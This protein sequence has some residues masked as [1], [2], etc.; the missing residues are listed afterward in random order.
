MSSPRLGVLRRAFQLIVL[1]WDGTAVENRRADAGAVRDRFE[2]LL[3]LGM[4][5]AVTTGTNFDNVDRQ[6]SAHIE[7]PHKGRLFV[8]T[9]R[10]SE[11]YGFGENSVPVVLQRRV[12]TAKEDSLLT[13]IVDAA[14]DTLS[15][16]TGLRFDVVYDRL[17]RR[18]L[19][20]L[21]LPEWADPP[22]SALGAVQAAADERLRRAG[23]SGGIAEVVALAE[24]TAAR[25]GL[26]EARITSDVKNVEIGLTDKGDAMRWIMREVCAPAG[27]A[28][29]DVLIVGDEFGPVGGM[30]GSDARML[31]PEVAEAV[32]V[33]VGPE[34]AGVPAGVLH[35]G[36]GPERFL[37]LLD[38]Q[39]RRWK[40]G[41]A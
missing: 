37:S 38:E 8:C 19:D 31:I 20:L 33:S 17:N 34:P 29:R 6:L 39:I 41:R 32:V 23:L 28:A 36:G 24:Q 10:G 15:A 1:D 16:R 13:A 21:P 11:V 7:G 22:K 27:I 35:L 14:R 5:I 4:P 9:S 25:L 3:Q 30:D 40:R 18:K 2:Q 26:P 12:A